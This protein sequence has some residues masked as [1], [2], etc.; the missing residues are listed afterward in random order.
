MPVDSIANHWC[1]RTS[2][3]RERKCWMFQSS[4]INFRVHAHTHGRC[5]FLILVFN[6]IYQ[7]SLTL[8]PRRLSRYYFVTGRANNFTTHT[9][10]CS[11]HYVLHL[12]NRETAGYYYSISQIRLIPTKKTYLK[13]KIPRHTKSAF[14]HVI[15][16]TSFIFTVPCQFKRFICRF[17]QIL[18][19]ISLLSRIWKNNIRYTRDISILLAYSW[20]NFDIAFWWNI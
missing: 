7:L 13:L 12:H 16:K 19:F 4:I 15:T 14:A 1:S 5:D 2:F 11:I 18:T 20:L 10:L 9:I 6:F 3:T 8:E 17:C